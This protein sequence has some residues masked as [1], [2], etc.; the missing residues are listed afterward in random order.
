MFF[1]LL[2]IAFLIFMAYWWSLQGLYSALLHFGLVLVSGAVALAFWEHLAMGL[3]VRVTYPFAWGMGLVLPF[4]LTLLITRVF[5]DSFA[6]RDP[7]IY[8]PLDYIGGAVFGF[9]GGY[10]AAGVL[11]LGLGFMPLPASILDFQ[12]KAVDA[13]GQVTDNPAGALWLRVDANTASFYSFLSSGAFSS[14]RPLATHQ[15]DLA[16]QAALHR[17]GFDPQASVTAVP[18]TVEVTA[19]LACPSPVNYI[20]DRVGDLIL[21]TAGGQQVRTAGHKLVA[22]STTW[23]A[24]PRGTYDTDQALRVYSSQIRLGAMGGKVDDPPVSLH[25][26]IGVTTTTGDAAAPVR[27]FMAFGD[28]KAQVFSTTKTSYLTWIFLVP[29]EQKVEY[30][31]VRH[32]RFEFAE[33]PKDDKAALAVAVGHLSGHIAATEDTPPAAPAVPATP[34]GPKTEDKPG[35]RVGRSAGAIAESIAIS[36]VLPQPFSQN[37]AAGFNIKDN[38]LISGTGDIAAVEGLARAL[39]IDRIQVP[40]HQ[41]AIRAK[42]GREQAQSLLGAAVSTAAALNPVYLKD[43]AGENYNAVGY[44]LVRSDRRQRVHLNLDAPLRSSKEIPVREMGP[45]DSLYLFF[46]VPKG[47]KLT[48]FHIGEKTFQSIDLPVP[49]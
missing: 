10:L 4:F 38:F 17:M 3:I 15:P 7:Q 41:A 47:V 9:L 2:L 18:G 45:Q 40:S 42:V 39:A 11:I 30:L 12:P 19:A 31:L 1:N 27:T 36:D 48:G 26:P 46:A 37:Y 23:K 33:E 16:T 24:E 44:A 49:R 13:T 21:K 25:A 35:F 43:S 20:D 5:L 29:A 6:P 34:E 14:E 28:D 32:L 8:P 22:V